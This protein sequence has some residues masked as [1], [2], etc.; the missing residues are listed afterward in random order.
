VVDVFDEVEEELRAERYT[1]WVRKGWP[2]AAG[3][4][5]LA[6]L[7]TLGVW[8][9]GEHQKSEQA[10]ASVTYDQALQ[11]LSSGDT[12]GADQKL[13]GLAASAPAGYRTLALM[14]RAGVQVAKGKTEE[15]VRLMDQAAKAAP[16]AVLADVA[17]LKAALLL[18][19]THPL[20]EIEQRLTPLIDDKRPY[21]LQAREAL[22]NARLQAGQPQLAQSDLSILT[23]APD[24]SP[25]ARA[26]AQAAQQ[27][28]RSGSAAALPAA[29]K[30]APAPQPLPPPN[31][32]APGLIPGA[33]Q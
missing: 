10:K 17:R 33:D 6:L 30:A 2:Y 27:L 12:E 7:V 26:R 11:A 8:G 25:Q 24:V 1:A 23:L 20:A 13:A 32:F 16:D 5:V 15:A 14:Q 28:I 3:A 21:H 19:D 9:F 4:V 31:G 22:A 18:M 29:S